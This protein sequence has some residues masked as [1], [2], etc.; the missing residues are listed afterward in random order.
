[1]LPGWGSSC[2]VSP[3][4]FQGPG[5][6][7]GTV[8]LSTFNLCCSWGPAC[9][10]SWFDSCSGHGVQSWTF[11]LSAQLPPGQGGWRLC[12]QSSQCS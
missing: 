1:M 6:G 12:A 2:E 4:I 5:K 9:F 10:L 7:L 3:H 8:V 11:G